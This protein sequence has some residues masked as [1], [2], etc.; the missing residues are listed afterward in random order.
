MIVEAQPSYGYFPSIFAVAAKIAVI[1][2]GALNLVY[3]CSGEIWCIVFSAAAIGICAL[4]ILVILGGWGIFAG[5]GLLCLA[6]FV[7]GILDLI[8]GVYNVITIVMVVLLGLLA[9]GLCGL[10]ARGYGMVAVF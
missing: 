5:P 1:V 3:N 8:F 9:F 7:V 10:H 2:L 6:V 4:D